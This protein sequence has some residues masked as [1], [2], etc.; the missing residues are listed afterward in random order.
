MPHNP[1]PLRASGLTKYQERYDRERAMANNPCPA[2]LCVFHGACPARLRAHTAHTHPHWRW[3]CLTCGD[4][5]CSKRAASAHRC[6]PLGHNP[7]N[8]P[9]AKHVVQIHML[10]HL[11]SLSAQELANLQAQWPNIPQPFALAPPAPVPGNGAWGAL[12]AQPPV[13]VQPMQL[14]ATVLFQNLPQGQFPLV[15]FVPNNAAL[16]PL[17]PAQ[18]QG[19][20]PLPAF[21][22]NNMALP[23][24]QAPMQPAMQ[25]NQAFAPIAPMAVQL[26]ANAANNTYQP[27]NHQPAAQPA[28]P[29]HLNPVGM[30]AQNPPALLPPSPD[31]DVIVE[32]VSDTESDIDLAPYNE[33]WFNDDGEEGVGDGD[34]VDE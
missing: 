19:Q 1:A 33:D 8:G 23:L 31:S 24:Q 32:E 10:T 22:P 2:P 21:N 20:Q 25:N 30:Q 34:E 27:I 7:H 6:Q 12:N 3:H 14:Q 4:W 9:A 15:P 11:R 26:A 18:P 28:A 5:W 17:P 13:Q 16:P 29:P